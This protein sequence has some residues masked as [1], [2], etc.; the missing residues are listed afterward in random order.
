[1]TAGSQARD[2]GEDAGVSQNRK[3]RLLVPQPSS[4]NTDNQPPRRRQYRTGTDNPISIS[5]N[6]NPAFF[7]WH[8]CFRLLCFL[9]IRNRFGQGERQSLLFFVRNI[10]TIPFWRFGNHTTKGAP[11]VFPTQPSLRLE[12]TSSGGPSRKGGLITVRTKKNPDT[13]QAGATF[14][15]LS[16]PY[17]AFPFGKYLLCLDVK[18]CRQ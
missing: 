2:A 10:S 3:I 13:P 12:P 5:K 14:S 1:M 18:G 16:L 4:S 9:L 15:H 17:I 7:F 11:I 8:F 6:K